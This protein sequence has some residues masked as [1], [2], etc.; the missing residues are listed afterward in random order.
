MGSDRSE[1]LAESRDRDS[2][3]LSGA[4]GYGDTLSSTQPIFD[5]TL[6]AMGLVDSVVMKADGMAAVTILGQTFGAHW[7]QV[8]VRVGDYAVAA[9]GADG[10]LAMLMPLQ[11]SY[12]PGA[13]PVWVAGEVSAV[14]ND[15][16]VFSVGNAAFNY[17]ALLARNPTLVPD[18]GD[19]VD[20]YGVQPVVG[21]SILLGITGGD[22]RGIT[23]GDARGITGGDGRGITGG[24]GRGI[25]GGDARGITGGDG[26][27]ITGGDAR[28]ITGGDARGITG[29]DA[30]GITG[31]DARGITGGDAR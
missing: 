1:N 19:A 3:H 13:S 27:G 17:T 16:G 9:S 11:E 23:G 18:V 20:M 12:V 31:G 5:Y 28:G 29:G 25:T 2:A 22:A 4:S 10:Q 21:G 24:D 7:D 8:S 6:A 14:Q 30:R 26:R 15:I